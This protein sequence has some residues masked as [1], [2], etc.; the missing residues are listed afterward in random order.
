MDSALSL[1]IFRP[2]IQ[3]YR[4]DVI[5]PLDNPW[6]RFQ[7]LRRH[8]PKPS[9]FKAGDICKIV[10]KGDPFK[11]K[12]GEVYYASGDHIEVLIGRYKLTYRQKDLK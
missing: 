10:K 8:K 7:W 4:A 12:T 9:K 6:E 3:I 1:R 11:G 5:R 2:K